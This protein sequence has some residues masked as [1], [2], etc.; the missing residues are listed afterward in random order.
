MGNRSKWAKPNAI[1]GQFSAYP[2]E[3]LESP[4]WRALTPSAKRCIERIAIELAKHGGRDNGELKVSNRRFR[5]FGVYMD[6]IKPALAE[7]VALGFIEMI[8]GYA[9]QN[10]NYGRTAQFRILFLN[11][12]GPL[13]D[14]TRWK[15]FKTY[16]EAKLTGKLAR[17]SAMQ[18]RRPK[19]GSHASPDDTET[20]AMAIDPKTGAIG[21]SRKPEQC[22][23]PK[24][25]AMST[26]SAKGRSGPAAEASAAPPAARASRRARPE[27]SGA[28]AAAVQPDA[29]EA[30]PI[31][32]SDQAPEPAP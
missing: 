14:H 9:C 15:R 1:V 4:A 8:P 22:P 5:A 23:P 28:P 24:T 11:C 19:A 26:V 29:G 12:K 3:M 21:A 25:G 27:R 20:G 6:G 13:P 2:I 16:E 7:A 17:A 31:P 10:P 32:W 30:E 18:K